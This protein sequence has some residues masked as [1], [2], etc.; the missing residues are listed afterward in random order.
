VNKNGNLVKRD[1]LK[2]GEAF[3]KGWLRKF[4]GKTFYN[5]YKNFIQMPK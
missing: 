5:G 4:C 2:I 3:S 1:R